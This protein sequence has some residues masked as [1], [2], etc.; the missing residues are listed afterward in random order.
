MELYRRPRGVCVASL[1]PPVA[2]APALP[3]ESNGVAGVCQQI[4]IDREPR[5][6]HIPVVTRLLQF[7]GVSAGEDARATWRTLRVGGEGVG[8][9]HTVLCYPVK[10]GCGEKRVAIGAHVRGIVSNGEEDVR[11]SLLHR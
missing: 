8:K 4:R 11:A 1:T 6:P 2:R 3:G 10:A 5:R 7:P 9:D